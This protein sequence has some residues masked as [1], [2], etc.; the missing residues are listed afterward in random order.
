M[1][2]G[3][4]HTGIGIER[5][6]IL[7]IKVRIHL[8]H[9]YTRLGTRRGR[10]VD[11]QHG[12]SLQF[13]WVVHRPCRGDHIVDIIYTDADLRVWLA[14]C[15]SRRKGLVGAA[16]SCA[17]GQRSAHSLFALSLI[18]LLGVQVVQTVLFTSQLRASI[19][20]ILKRGENG[21]SFHV[22]TLN[23]TNLDYPYPEVD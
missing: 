5:A 12:H 2:Q 3:G 10:A 6:R 17:V 18:L 19:L 20:H 4:K 9:M 14:H 23:S 13:R 1:R 8:V 15:S 7:D 21:H 22:C 11:P 16:S